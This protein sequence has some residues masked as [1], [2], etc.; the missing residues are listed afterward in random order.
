MLYFWYLPGSNPL[1]DYHEIW[2]GW[3]LGVRNH[4][5]K[6]WFTLVYRFLIG[7]RQK[8]T[9]LRMRCIAVVDLLSRLKY[10][11]VNTAVTLII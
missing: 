6:V 7:A 1:T 2:N 8:L 4:L 11:D 9:L 10:P 3:S 5:E